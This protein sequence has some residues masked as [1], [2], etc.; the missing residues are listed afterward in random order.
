MSQPYPV[1]LRPLSEQDGGGWLAEIRALPGCIADGET[2]QEAMDSIEE[3][4][5][6]WLTIALRERRDIPLPEPDAEEEYSGRIT[7]RMPRSLHRKLV[8]LA[9]KEGMSLNQLLLSQI[10]YKTALFE[11]N[12]KSSVTVTLFV[13]HLPDIEDISPIVDVWKRTDSSLSYLKGGRDIVTEAI[14][15]EDHTNTAGVIEHEFAGGGLVERDQ[16]LE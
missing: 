10:S 16:K 1:L 11:I 2:P 15:A 13:P 7:L 5:R 12:T 14:A 9:L 4:K 6:L 8:E 3:S